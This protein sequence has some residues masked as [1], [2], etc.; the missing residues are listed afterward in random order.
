MAKFVTYDN[1]ITMDRSQAEKRIIEL[2]K[3]LWENSRKYYVDNAPVISDYE[4]DHLMYEL[5]DL[6]KQFPEF[7]TPDSPTRKVGSDLE[8]SDEQGNT[9]V[10]AKREFA[11]YPHKYPMLSLGNTYSIGEVEAFTARATKSIGKPFTYSCEL[12][13]D[14]TAICLTYRD[15]KLLRALTRGDGVIGDDVTDNVRHI[16][17]IPV[18]L[19]GSGYP[20]EFEIRGEIL[21]PYKAF[22][23]LNAERMRNE[24]QP[25]ANPRNAASGSLK[26]LDPE[27]V[28]KRGLWCT[29]YH[30]PSPNVNFAKP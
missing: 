24:D 26:L 6:E 19:H 5:A 9:L 3:I 17:N 2:R 21:M 13:F 25:F 30:I 8:N 7:I 20:E 18:R 29:L 10:T 14:G 16:S 23:E 11:Q 22:D 12:K 28:G 27:E 4:Y 1:F 15:G